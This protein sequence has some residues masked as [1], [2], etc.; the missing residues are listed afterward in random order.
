MV[1]IHL[2]TLLILPIINCFP[3]NLQHQLLDNQLQL[4]LHNNNSN[5]NK[6]PILH[7]LSNREQKYNNNLFNLLSPVLPLDSHNNFPLHFNNLNSSRNNSHPS[8]TTSR[9]T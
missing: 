4:S 2:S 8:L 1:S 7:F 9:E 6:P 5:N 3:H